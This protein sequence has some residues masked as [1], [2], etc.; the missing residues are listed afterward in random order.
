MLYIGGHTM[1]K[2]RANG[3]GTIFQRK[4][5]KLWVGRVPIGYKSNGSIKLQTVYGRT[6]KE[7]KE[8][9]DEAKGNIKN[10]SFVEPHKITLQ[11]WLDTWLNITIKGSIKDTTW[12]IYE[13]LI[14]NHIN[15]E[16]GGIRLLNLQASHIQKLYNDKLTGGRS[17]K[18]KN[19]ETGELEQ[20]EGGLSPKTIRH[21]HQVIKGSLDQAIKERYL[22]INPASAVKLP[23]LLKKEMKTLSIEQVKMFL[24][25]ASTN[26]FYK[27]YYTAYLLELYTG[28]RRGELLGLR[29]K[30]IDFKNYTIKVIQQLVKVGSSHVLRELKTESSQ[31]RV[32]AITDDVIQALKEHKKNKAAEYKFIGYDEL[33][34]KKMLSEGLVFTNELGNLLQPRNFLR[35]FKG[36]LKASGIDSIRFHDMRHTFALLSLQQ[37]VDIKTLQSDLGHESIETTLDRYGHVNED[38]KRD[39]AKKREKV[40]KS[41][42]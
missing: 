23:K 10:N 40:I 24:E 5:D 19:K 3:E 35:N 21:I 27:R 41:L 2:K 25:T 12:L 37:G 13:S 26:Q 14:K 22:S 28:L 32:I 31:N 36:A 16:I 8:K 11:Q 38:M 33:S 39:A 30:D 6:Q 4:S 1:S 17:D 7:V 18:K 9:I 15:P 42:L 29:W 34:V 20:K